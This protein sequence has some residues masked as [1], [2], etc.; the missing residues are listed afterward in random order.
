MADLV[1]FRQWLCPGC[2]V[3]LDTEIARPADPWLHDVDIHEPV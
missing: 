2:G 3:R 1:V